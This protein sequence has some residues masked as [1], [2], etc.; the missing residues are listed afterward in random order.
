MSNSR[1]RPFR[2]QS[3]WLAIYTQTDEVVARTMAEEY[4]IY[5]IEP[6]DMPESLMYNALGMT[7]LCTIVVPA[8][9][10]VEFH[11]RCARLRA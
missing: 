4:G 11:Q 9:R 5:V 10:L 6:E 8:D 7:A 3:E 2:N 1:V